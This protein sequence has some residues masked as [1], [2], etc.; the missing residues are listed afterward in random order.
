MRDTAGISSRI[1]VWCVTTDPATALG[2]VR[3]GPRL[4]REHGQRP[5]PVEASGGQV[6]VADQE[7]A[8][9]YLVL[10]LELGQRYPLAPQPGCLLLHEPVAVRH[11]ARDRVLRHAVLGV[12]AD[13][14]LHRIAAEVEVG[15][16]RHLRPELLEY[17][18]EIVEVGGVADL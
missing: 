14:Q 17:G 11:V 18:A 8:D 1:P 10:Q 2:P 12:F 4:L 9:V 15:A 7:A 3:R 13:A 16:G 5:N 6:F